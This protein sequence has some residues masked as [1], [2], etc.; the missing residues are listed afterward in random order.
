[1][2]SDGEALIDVVLKT[3]K[4]KH[5]FKI[6][7]DSAIS[8]L[9]G[10][11][12]GEF[13]S[14]V[15]RVVLIFSGKILKDADTVKQHNIKDGH[16]VHVVIKMNK[17]STPA[18][19]ASSSPTAQSTTTSSAGTTQPSTNPPPPTNPLG[20]GMGSLF[21]SLGSSM[22]GDNLA[23]MQEQM[24]NELMRNPEALQNIMDSPM[25]RNMMSNPDMIHQMVVNNPQMQQLMERNPEIGHMLNNPQLMRQTLEMARNPAMLQELMRNQDRALSNL[26]SIPGGYNALQRMY[27][28]YQEPMMNAAEEQFGRNPFAALANNQG[29]EDANTE[30]QNTE[31]TEPLPNPWGGGGGGRATAGNNTSSTGNKNSKNTKSSTGATTGGGA[32]A[33]GLG[34]MA[35]MFNNPAMQSMMEQVRNN[36]DMFNSM[37][38]SPYMQTMMQNLSSNPQMAQQ[39][40]SQDPMFANN[41]QMQ[42]ML[43]ELLQSMQRP[44]TLQAL[45]NPRAREAMMQVQQGLETLRQEAPGIFPDMAGMTTGAANPATTGANTGSTTNN[46]PARPNVPNAAPNAD[47][48]RQMME[49]LMGNQPG[50]QQQQ[51]N[52]PPESRFRQQLD[53]LSQMGFINRDANVRALVATNGN[54]NQAV[55][56]LLRNP[57]TA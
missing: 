28:E 29:S 35:G 32:A 4:V 52:T 44:E 43:P 12:A 20:M 9:R 40:L 53:Q 7:P 13:K 10:K 6:S 14:P 54:V 5:T 55:E 36:P 39:L 50:S 41:P 15:D 34:G 45:T 8:E 57:G 51:N 38:S 23:Q 30:P 19:A 17:P 31:N 3:P 42:G 1:M 48:L 46:S 18:S 21:G 27:T 56:F 49:N 26:E 2:A 11:A 47:F 24:H 33:G 37:L 22:G 16:T 25:M